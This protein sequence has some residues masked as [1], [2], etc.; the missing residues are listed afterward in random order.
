MVDDLTSATPEQLDEIYRLLIRP[1]LGLDTPPGSAA[2]TLILLGGQPGSGTARVAARLIVDDAEPIAALRGDDLRTFHPQYLPGVTDHLAED[3]A[4]AARN[5]V[6]SALQNALDSRVS[7]LLEGGFLDARLTL[8]TAER[9]RAAGFQVRLVAVAA[10]AALSLVSV[11]SRFLRDRRASL[12]PA[13]LSLAAHDRSFSGA[14]DVVRLIDSTPAP[15][16]RVT[17]VGRTGATLLDEDGPTDGRAVV[18]FDAGRKPSSWGA[19]ST[20]ELLGELKQVT[21]YAIDS[22]ELG[23]GVGDVLIEAHRRALEDVVPR[24][25]VDPDSPQAGLIRSTVISQNARLLSAIELAG[26]TIRPPAQIPTP[27]TSLDF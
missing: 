17:I 10:P 19:R 16:D 21:G 14:A 4:D 9:F 24:L 18:A 8:G 25:S 12:T 15:I 22:G 20:M 6:R 27:D 5:W 2:P 3:I 1:S 7:L 26:E 13:P 11:A 23:H